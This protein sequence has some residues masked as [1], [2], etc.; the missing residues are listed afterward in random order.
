MRKKNITLLIRRPRSTIQPPALTLRRVRKW[1]ST[2]V[3]SDAGFD[4]NKVGSTNF[5]AVK[6]WNDGDR[7]FGGVTSFLRIPRAEVYKLLAMQTA[8]DYDVNRKLEWLCSYRGSIYMYEILGDSWQ[9]A[10]SIRWGTIAIGGNLVQVE[11]YETITVG[12]QVFNMARLRGFRRS[13][14]G[15]PRDELIAEGLVH[16]CYCAYIRPVPNS[17]GDSPKGIVYSP[18]FSPLDYDYAGTKQPTALYLPVDWLE[19]ET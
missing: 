15:R 13:D 4:V 3:M 10:N 19:P 2:G 18:F 14:W 11:R 1:S 17:F 9:T 7:T 12:G 8:D 6:V 5:Q 16:R